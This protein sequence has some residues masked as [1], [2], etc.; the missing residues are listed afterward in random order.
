MKCSVKIRFRYVERK[1]VVIVPFV[2]SNHVSFASS[3]S[4]LYGLNFSLMSVSQ[5]IPVSL[6]NGSEF[7]NAYVSYKINKNSHSNKTIEKTLCH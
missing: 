7:S 2:T 3:E 1:G 5:A 6:I 4:G